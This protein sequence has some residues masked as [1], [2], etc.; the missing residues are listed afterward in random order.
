MARSSHGA[1]RRAGGYYSF[2]IDAKK[3]CYLYAY[4]LVA[5]RR[6]GAYVALYGPNSRQLFEQLTTTREETEQTVGEKL[7]WE[8]VQ[9]DRKYCIGLSLD[10]ADALD[11]GDWARQH[12]WLISRL[13]RLYTAF[14]PRIASLEVSAAAE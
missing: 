10:S 14:V 3:N 9:P 8:E 11:E 7:L 2:T 1:N 6:I 13:D 4:R 12:D 5:K